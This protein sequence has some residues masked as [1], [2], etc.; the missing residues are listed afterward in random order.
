VDFA[1]SFA[2][3]GATAV[4]FMLL[5]LLPGVSVPVLLGLMLCYALNPIVT[6]LERRGLSRSLGAGAVFGSAGAG[7]ALALVYLLPTF[8]AQ[9]IKLPD[10][11]RQAGAEWVPRLEVRL[12]VSVPQFLQQRAAELG[13]QASNLL[14]TTAPSAAGFLATFAGNTARLLVTAASLLV[15]PVLAFFFLRDYPKLIE[16]GRSLLPRRFKTLLCERF[17]E[18]DEVLSAFIRGELTVGAILFVWYSVGLSL[19]HLPMAI[20]IAFIAGFGVMVP[21]VGPAT[22]LAL[23]VLGLLVGWQGS[24]Q[25]IIV[26]VTFGLAQMMEGLVLTPRIVGYKVGL[27][28]VAVIVAVLAFGE[29]FGFTGVLLAVPSSAVLKVALRVF[30]QR[31]Q[32]MPIYTGETAR[33]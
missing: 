33:K 13:A 12:G 27:P 3:L 8:R 20:V 21:Y 7:L 10:L 1:W 28:P 30:I 16:R 19:A 14:K 22:G 25:V 9:F 24:T 26:L 32:K 29:L 6:R 18:V 11:I 2:M 17:V 31:Y 15:V 4:L 23:A 5:S